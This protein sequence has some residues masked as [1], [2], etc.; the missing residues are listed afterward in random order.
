MYGTFGLIFNLILTMNKFHNWIDRSTSTISKSKV[1]SS[2]K[3]TMRSIL[4]FTFILNAIPINV[5]T[6]LPLFIAI[7]LCKI[8]TWH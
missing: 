5:I 4:L 3:D 6:Q 8:T 2:L 1:I 7:R